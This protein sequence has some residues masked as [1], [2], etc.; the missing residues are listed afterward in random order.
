MSDDDFVKKG[1]PISTRATQMTQTEIFSGRSSHKRCNDLNPVN[2]LASYRSTFG[3]LDTKRVPLD[4]TFN[5]SG[6]RLPIRV[7]MSNEMSLEPVPVRTPSK[8]VMDSKKALEISDDDGEVEEAFDQFKV[9]IFI[10]SSSRCDVVCCFPRSSDERIMKLQVG[11]KHAFIPGTSLNACLYHSSHRGTYVEMDLQHF[12]FELQELL[13]LPPQAGSVQVRLTF[14][15]NISEQSWE[16]LLARL[17]TFYPSIVEEEKPNP[18]KAKRRISQVVATRGRPPMSA[19][20]KEFNLI[21]RRRSSSRILRLT[22]RVRS[23]ED[24]DDGGLEIVE[25]PMAS[26]R[27]L[28]NYPDAEDAQSICLTSAERDRLK[29]GVFLNDTLIDFDIMRTLSRLESH[30]LSR[31]HTFNCF[32]YKRL[33]SKRGVDRFTRNLDIF[34][35]DLVFVPINE[36]L[37][38]YLGVIVNPAHALLGSQPQDVESGPEICVSDDEDASVRQLSYVVM[39]DSLGHPRSAAIESLKRFMIEEAATKHGVQLDKALLRGRNLK[40]PR[41]PNLTDCGLF[42]LESVERA[43]RDIDVTLT[44]FVDPECNLTNWFAPEAA[45]RRRAMLLE[46]MDRLSIEYRERHPQEFEEQ[47]HS[48]SSD[49]EMFI[50]DRNVS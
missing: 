3:H 24:D 49:V 7:Q 12:S 33:T 20:A 29:P 21:D 45:S 37:H 14:D 8:R 43:L 35:K 38:W 34:S 18:F 41:Q 23:E 27:F 22:P 48:A 25:G 4:T 44:H 15:K 16:I 30:C 5:H 19:A 10:E 2:T 17:L 13:T 32:F 50:P 46:E 40:V 28:F 31:I 1:R 47:V 11:T 42:L 39:L 26:I 9:D 36:A 6:G